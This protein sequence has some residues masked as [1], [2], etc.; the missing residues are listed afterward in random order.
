MGGYFSYSFGFIEQ[1]AAALLRLFKY[2]KWSYVTALRRGAIYILV[3]KYY[4]NIFLCILLNFK[5]KILF[6]IE[7]EKPVGMYSDN[8]C[9]LPIFEGKV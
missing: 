5:S 3:F 2:Y 4:G 6:L 9:G 8:Y 7:K 1:L